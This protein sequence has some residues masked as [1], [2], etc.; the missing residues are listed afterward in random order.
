MSPQSALRTIEVSLLSKVKF[1]EKHAITMLTN[2]DR[3]FC[4]DLLPILLWIY[5]RFRFTSDFTLDLLPKTIKP[6]WPL[7]YRPAPGQFKHSISPATVKTTFSW[8]L[9]WNLEFPSQKCNSIQNNNI[10]LTFHGKSVYIYNHPFKLG[11]KVP[12]YR[13]QVYL[14]SDLWVRM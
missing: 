5:F 11:L 9:G 4:P 7:H 8:R 2:T 12:F 10:W 14:G 1:E 6:A 13:T 3:A